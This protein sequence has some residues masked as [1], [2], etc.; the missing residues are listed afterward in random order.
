[1]T[2]PKRNSRSEESS[3]G[4]ATFFVTTSTVAR[5][6]FFQV[7]RHAE[8][9]AKILFD[10]RKSAQFQLHEF[11]IMP[12]H[13]HLLITVPSGVTVEKALQLVKGGFSFQAG[14]LFNTNGAIWQR[15][16]SEIRIFELEGFHARK[17][18]IRQNAVQAGLVAN[19]EEF[20]FC[21]A[22][23]G[24]DLDPVPKNFGG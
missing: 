3:Q 15:G 16:F 6:R 5:R 4:S 2:I 22:F 8:L 9:F 17:H 14:K 21:S 18:Y 24:Y 11:C 13:I 1:M 20:R 10:Y 7:E 12:D 23:P 19:A